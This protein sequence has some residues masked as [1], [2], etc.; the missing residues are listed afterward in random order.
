[1]LLYTEKSMNSYL[2]E[3]VRL[4]AS[5]LSVEDYQW[6][7]P[8]ELLEQIKAQRTDVYSKLEA[9]FSAYKKW[10]AFHVNVEN[11]GKAGN[12]SAEETNELH[13]LIKNR[14]SLRK[15]LAASFV[16]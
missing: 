14:D 11:E 12:L 4:S 1:M 5:K 10:H 16:K 7:E 6:L 3:I 13:Q 2:I 8:S 9:F 15:E